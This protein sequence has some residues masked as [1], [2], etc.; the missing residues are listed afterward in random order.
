MSLIIEQI[1]LVRAMLPAL[2]EKI[3]PAKWG[4]TSLP[5]I[6]APITWAEEAR[7]AL[8]PD[9]P[10]VVIDEI[11]GCKVIIDNERAPAHPILIDHDGKVYSLELTPE[12]LAS[13]VDAAPVSRIIQS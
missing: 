7:L 3:D 2:K 11:A 13:A 12:M 9:D 1:A 4:E 10:D 6:V 5:I 8:A